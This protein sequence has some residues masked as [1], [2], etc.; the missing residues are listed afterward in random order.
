[1]A[2]TET[3]CLCCEAE[4][5]RADAILNDKNLAERDV[6]RLRR[7]IQALEM[8]LRTEREAD[9]ERNP[10]VAHVLQ[11]WAKAMG[12]RKT[13]NIGP[14]STRAEFMGKVLKRRGYSLAGV[15]EA[16]DGCAAVP[17]VGPR[18][19]QATPVPGRRNGGRHDDL[20]LIFRDDETYDRFR[21]YARDFQTQLEVERLRA[22]G[23]REDAAYELMHLRLENEQLEA[24]ATRVWDLAS[25]EDRMLMAEKAWAERVRRD[26]VAA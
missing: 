16:I 25:P 2:L 1:M 9:T 14:S 12:K 11:H 20:S 19:R 26:V 18:G 10:D 5:L 21:G 6:V 24:F 13:T 7:V 22:C 8:R 17:Y 4:R 15:L 3:T 23:V